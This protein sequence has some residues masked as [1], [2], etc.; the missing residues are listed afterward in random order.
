MISVACALTH[1][2]AVAETTALVRP[3]ERRP[4]LVLFAASG[5]GPRP[6]RAPCCCPRRASPTT[7]RTRIVAHP[8]CTKPPTYWAEFEDGLPPKYTPDALGDSY[9]LRKLS[10]DPPARTGRAYTSSFVSRLRRRHAS[11][12]LPARCLDLRAAVRLPSPRISIAVSL[13]R[14]GVCTSPVRTSYRAPSARA[15]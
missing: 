3:V 11:R 10:P 5:R 15:S 12:L 7:S 4:S 2:P 13:P 6:P 14:P 8:R 1:S 9:A